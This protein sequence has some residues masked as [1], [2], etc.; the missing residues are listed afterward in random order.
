[1]CQSLLKEGAIS[2][3]VY[4]E[5]VIS[6]YEFYRKPEKESDSES[7]ELSTDSFSDSDED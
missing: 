1:M 5:K 2:L 7:D 4:V 6:F 3:E